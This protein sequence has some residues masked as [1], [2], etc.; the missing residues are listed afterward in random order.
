MKVEY[1]IIHPRDIKRAE[2]TDAP[3]AIE[4]LQAYLNQLGAEG[5]HYEWTMDLSGVKCPV[6]SRLDD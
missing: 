5:W 6:M 1:K 2:W 4:Q 3:V